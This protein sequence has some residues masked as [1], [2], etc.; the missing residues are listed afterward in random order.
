MAVNKVEINGQIAIDL[1]QDTVTPESLKK[2]IIAHSASGEKIVGTGTDTS[3][4]VR[5]NAI[6]VDRY[7]FIGEE[8]MATFDLSG[9]ITGN[10]FIC[11]FYA[12][13]R[14]ENTGA[15]VYI[16]IFL[17]CLGPNFRKGTVTGYGAVQD[18]NGSFIDA[19][20]INAVLESD[21]GHVYDISSDF[22]F[23]FDSDGN[24]LANCYLDAEDLGQATSYVVSWS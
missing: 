21:S 12:P 8:M 24:P 19:A 11:F 6:T 4:D 1:T 2:G 16:L 3:I 15:T 20:Q 22:A 13:G 7:Q 18:R 23:M 14:Q 17:Q 5:L 9:L 10:S